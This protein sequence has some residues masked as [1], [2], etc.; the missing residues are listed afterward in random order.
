[1]AE[2]MTRREKAQSRFFQEAG[3]TICWH[4]NGMPYSRRDYVKRGMRPP[5]RHVIQ[6]SLRDETERR[7]A[8]AAN[9]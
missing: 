7:Q 9:P 6:Q 1:M 5:P 8:R 3:T 2:Q 4:K